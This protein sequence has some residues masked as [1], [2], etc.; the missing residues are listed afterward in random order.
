MSNIFFINLCYGKPIMSKVSFSNDLH[1][2][3]LIGYYCTKKPCSSAFAICYIALNPLQSLVYMITKY[4]N[5]SRY[6]LPVRPVSY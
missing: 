6:F 4:F 3:C 1:N 5:L 2:L